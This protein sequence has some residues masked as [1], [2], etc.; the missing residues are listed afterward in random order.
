M[1]NTLEDTSTVNKPETVGDCEQETR[2]V[3]IC[4]S[5][6]FL[7]EMLRYYKKLS[8]NGDIVL[9]PVFTADNLAPQTKMG[10]SE[11]QKAIVLTTSNE[12]ILT[13]KSRLFESHK[14]KIL[15]SDLIFVVN[16]GGYHGADTEKEIAFA[17][18]HGI[19]VDYMEPPIN[20]D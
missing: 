18:G 5:M 4:G 8:M 3:T 19:R 1:I 9:L 16:P 13:E 6:K 10:F 15:M 11:P 2:I 7:P 20:T 12:G 14:K 17:I